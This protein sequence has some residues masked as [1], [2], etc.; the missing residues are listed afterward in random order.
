MFDVVATKRCPYCA[1][2]IRIQAIKCRYCAS[3]LDD[4]MLTRSWRRSRRGRRIAGVCAGLAEEFAISV[5]LIR[6]AFIL[7]TVVGGS[8]I[9]I[10]LALWVLMPLTPTDEMR[11]IEPYDPL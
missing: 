3:R 7:A 9:I 6:L 10:Y 1:E 8:G 5:T 11:E 2:E 4:G